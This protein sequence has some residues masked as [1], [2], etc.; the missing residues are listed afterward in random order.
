M[1]AVAHLSDIHVDDGERSAER[2]RRVMA[3]LENLPKPIDA[4]VVTGDIAN[5]GELAEYRLAREILTSR[6]PVFDCPGNH[7]IRAA[8]RQGLLGEPASD[9]PVNQVREI[10]GATF[11]LCDSTIPGAAEGFLADETI[12]W[13]DDALADSTGPAFVCFHHPPADLGHPGLDSIKQ[14]GA[15]RL[16]AVV[17]RHP[18]VV[19][20][21]CGH[22]H[23]PAVTTFAGRPLLMAPGVVSSSR[24][25]FEPNADRA[26][27]DGG[28]VDFD[29]PPMVAFHLLHDGNR[30][31]THF[32]A[33]VA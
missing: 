18:R 19:G 7:D 32:R 20:M 33:V 17:E 3:Y 26:W 27:E 9:A 8:Y 14:G 21:L 30:L 13:L 6:Y 23:T 10:T 31:T 29:Q 2:A 25:P 15:E 1:I 16:A 5:N 24:L 4:I 11:L 22:A 28:P 12:E